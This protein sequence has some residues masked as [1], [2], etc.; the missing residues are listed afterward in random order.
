LTRLFLLRDTGRIFRTSC[1][2]I[3]ASAVHRVV[4]VAGSL[5]ANAYFRFGG[6]TKLDALVARGYLAA[7]E[8]EDA[9]AVQAALE[10]FLADR[11]SGG[12]LH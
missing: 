10:A 2:T 6:I 4:T 11:L 3:K 7:D 8:R 12:H 9:E 5:P 1:T